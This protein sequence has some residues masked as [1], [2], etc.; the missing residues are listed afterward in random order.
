MANDRILPVI[1]VPG[2]GQSRTDMIDENGKKICRAWPLDIDTKA[3]VKRIA[4]SLGA[5]LLTRRD[6]GFSKALYRALGEAL[7]PLK[8]GFDGRPKNSLRVETFDSP[9]SECSDDEKHFIGRMI[10]YKYFT[11]VLGEE[12]LFYYAFNPFGCAE[13]TVNSLRDFIVRVK[14]KTKSEKV[15]LIA[16]SLGGTLV[17]QYLN[18]YGHHRDI[19]RLVG[20]VSA[21]DGSTTISTIL[22][23]TLPTEK[24]CGL[25]GELFG[26]GLGEK[27]SK[28]F[29]KLPD[30]LKNLYK[31][32]VFEAL[33]DH[34]L[35][36]NTTMWGAVPSDDYM[37]IRDSLLLKKEFDA[38]RS[39]T[40]KAF[41]VRN[42]FE[43]LV[44]TAK[45]NGTGI[46]S[47]CGY[48]LPMFVSGTDD[49]SDGIVH[50]DSCA[51]GKVSS[52]IG[53]TLS[54]QDGSVLSDD[55]QIDASKSA[56]SD[57]VWY[58]KNMGH[59]QCAKEEK[60][61]RLASLLLSDDSI[62]NANSSDEFPQFSVCK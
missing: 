57:R 9:L 24:F 7:E 13:D 31:D 41:N 12:N 20:I 42:D 45:E 36:C 10:P 19:H 37:R 22:G 43:K 15:N 32:T 40:D 5:M 46:F 28:V 54:T 25:I 1:V 17:T 18:E 34:L 14:E 55:K 44:S 33:R 35:L 48:S 29:N 58:F 21:F 6:C 39:Y 16:I 52:R 62:Q 47:L 26:K 3:L 56:L 8:C 27:V 2:I 30:R 60:L 38:I 49:N 4:P 23:N 51:M 61:L 53:E 59:E 50:V 11:D